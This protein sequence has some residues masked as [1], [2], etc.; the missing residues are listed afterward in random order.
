MMNNRTISYIDENED[1]LESE[2]EMA[3]KNSM[4][5]NFRTYCD[6][7]ASLCAMS[8]IDVTDPLVDK[9]I[10]YLEDEY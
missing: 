6:L 4:E 1:P 10:Y 3:L 9:T 7:I 2:V 8:N 5:E